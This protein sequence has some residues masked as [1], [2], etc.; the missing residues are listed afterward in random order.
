MS[1]GKFSGANFLNSRAA[2]LQDSN[3]G[4]VTIAP[5]GNEAGGNYTS[6]LAEAIKAANE[7]TKPKK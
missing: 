3:T 6:R 5:T 4:R 7:S 1:S 2:D